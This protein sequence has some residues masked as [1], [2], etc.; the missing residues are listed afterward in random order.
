MGLEYGAATQIGNE[1]ALTSHMRRMSPG[2]YL[3]AMHMAQEDDEDDE[4]IVLTPLDAEQQ[5]MVDEQIAFRDRAV[6]EFRAL[7]ESGTAPCP[8][9]W[10]ALTAYNGTSECMKTSKEVHDG[11]TG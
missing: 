5:A 9:G 1:I 3:L 6:A 4:T 2:A 8:C 7:T 10:R 11:P